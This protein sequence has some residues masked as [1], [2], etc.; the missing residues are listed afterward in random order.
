MVWALI[1]AIS[2]SRPRQQAGF[3]LLAAAFVGFYAVTWTGWT[4]TYRVVL[5]AMMASL[6]CEVFGFVVSRTRASHGARQT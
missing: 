1:E 4:F 6:L 3:A 5:L 2:A